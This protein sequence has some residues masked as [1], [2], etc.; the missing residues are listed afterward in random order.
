[1]ANPIFKNIA[2]INTKTVLSFLSL[3]VSAKN[4]LKTML[5]IGLT[6]ISLSACDSQDSFNKTN[7]NTENQTTS[8]NPTKT[9]KQQTYKNQQLLAFVSQAEL[10]F[11]QLKQSSQTLKSETLRFIKA[12]SEKTIEPV[13]QSLKRCHDDYLLTSLFRHAVTQAEIYHPTINAP[14]INTEQDNS[15]VIHSNHIRLDQHPMIAGYLDAVTGYPSSGLIYSEQS[16]SE[17]FLNTEHQFTDTAYVAMGFHAL[18]FMLN[19]DQE[20]SLRE[21]S[22]FERPDSLD[23]LDKDESPDRSSPTKRRSQYI[24]LL[25]YLIAEDINKLSS[26]WLGEESFYQVSLSNKHKR[27]IEK[28]LKDSTKDEQVELIE[29]EKKL[30][31]DS[32]RISHTDENLLELRKKQLS[33]LIESL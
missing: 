22:D 23:I 19:G 11:Q 2:M 27:S 3:S 21:V 26:A 29:L 20:S 17:S 12:P 6:F 8:V 33:T 5:V 30:T 28:L 4:H 7:D 24:Q 32:K 18:D 10:A 13:R 1:M 14:Q 31:K 25:A 15:E 16:I 9:D